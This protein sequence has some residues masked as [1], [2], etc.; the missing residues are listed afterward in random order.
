MVEALTY[1]GHREKLRLVG[2]EDAVEA[3][4]RA[5]L[6]IA[7]EVAEETGTL[8]AGNICNSTLA[9]VEDHDD[10]DLT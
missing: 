9:L 4:N 6:R 8:F 3:L 5:A 2:Q 10:Q 1:Y 7:K